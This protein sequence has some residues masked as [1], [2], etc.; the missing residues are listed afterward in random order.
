MAKVHIEITEDGK[1][2]LSRDFDSISISENRHASAL[3]KKGIEKPV[4]IAPSAK[5]RLM[6]VADE[7]VI[8]EGAEYYTMDEPWEWPESVLADVAETKEG[9]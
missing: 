7:V 6:I 4:T 8:P 5:I 9:E 2:V 3:Y 1:S